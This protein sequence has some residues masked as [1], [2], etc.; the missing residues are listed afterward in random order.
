MLIMQTEWYVAKFPQSPDF[1]EMR[2][3]ALNSWSWELK[4]LLRPYSSAVMVG[5]I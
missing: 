1:I 2:A 4:D 3:N 5:G